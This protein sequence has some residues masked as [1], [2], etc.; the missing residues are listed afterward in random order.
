VTLDH[1]Q[2]RSP[3]KERSHHCLEDSE[4]G[5]E[6]ILKAAEVNLSRVLPF[7][8]IAILETYSSLASSWP[9][10]NLYKSNLKAPGS[11]AWWRTPLIPA[12]GRQ[13]QADF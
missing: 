9:S 1:P 12:L 6:C 2:T 7:A 4:V 13:R 8:S 10:L 3:H 11:R 5:I